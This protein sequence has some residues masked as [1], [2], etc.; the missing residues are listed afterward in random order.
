MGLLSGITNTYKKSEA[1]LVVRDLLAHQVKAGYCSFD[2]ELVSRKLIEMVWKTKPDIFA[3]KFGQ[4]PHKLAVAAFA[5]ALGARLF[6]EGNPNRAALVI[7]LGN[8]LSEL[9][10]NGRLYPLNSLDHVLLETAVAT[11]KVATDNIPD[12][13]KD[14]VDGPRPTYD[15]FEAWYEVFKR[16]AG[17]LNPQ[18]K[19]G[20]NGF[21]LVDVMEHEPLRNAFRA[22]VD[23]EVLAR[24][25]A[26]TFDIATFGQQRHAT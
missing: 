23:P 5:L 10:V 8:L 7:A 21:S 18:L 15:N 17:E 11:F 6:D 4:R 24:E 12:A 1:S 20:T 9:E 22:S 19:T 3:G 26:S 14:F 25:F 2:P 13:L 16:V